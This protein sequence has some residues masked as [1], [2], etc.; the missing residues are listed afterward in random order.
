MNDKKLFE[1]QM[2]EQNVKRE[3]EKLAILSP[4][5]SSL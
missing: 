1:F 5:V 4:G 3:K 2:F